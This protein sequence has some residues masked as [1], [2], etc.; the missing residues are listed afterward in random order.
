MSSKKTV[1]EVLPEIQ[2]KLNAPKNQRNTFGNYNYRTCEGI[3]EA[4]KPLLDGCY[5]ILDDSIEEIGGRIYVRAYALISDGKN[6]ISTTAYARETE[7]K[8]GMDEAQITGAASSYARKYALNGLFCID[9]TKDAD[10]TNKHDK[11]NITDDGDKEIIKTYTRMFQSC[12]KSNQVTDII[13]A[14][15]FKRLS[16]GLKT[17]LI[18]LGR[19]AYKELDK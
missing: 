10:S 4:V 16:E 8:K 14:D 6:Q 5:L 17:H 19:A 9:D 18:G 3:L 11:E 1:Y 12:K 13:N 7:N 15:D 2:S